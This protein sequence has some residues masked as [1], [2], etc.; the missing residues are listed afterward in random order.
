[1]TRWRF[2]VATAIA[3]AAIASSLAACLSFEATEVSELDALRDDFE[4]VSEMLGARCG[5]LDCHGAPGR[6]LRLFHHY[7][8]RRAR[9]DVPGGDETRQ[10]EHDANFLAVT[11]LEPELTAEVAANDGEGMTDLILYGKAYGL[12][13]HKGSEILV[14]GTDADRCLVSWLAGRVDVERCAAAS[15]FV[16]PDE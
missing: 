15:T 12:V 13:L 1:M 16:R 9:G 10:E 6:S 14:E 5:S 4:P 2:L 7:G 8:Y 3:A 11:G